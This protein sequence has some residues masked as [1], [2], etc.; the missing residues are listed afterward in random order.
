MTIKIIN[1]KNEHDSLVLD[2]FYKSVYHTRNEFEAARTPSW[3]HRYSLEP[4]TIKYLALKNGK[5]VGSL[6]LIT[7]LGYINGHKYKVGFFVDNCI[8]PEYST[9]YNIILSRLFYQI[10]K[11]AKKM[12]IDL[13]VGWDYKKHADHHNEL[14]TSMGYSRIDGINWIGGGTKHVQ[15]ISIKE[16]NLPLLWKIGL[17]ILNYKHHIR[18]L[19]LARLKHE[20][21]RSIHQKDIPEIVRIINNQNRSLDLSP[22]YTSTSLNRIMKKYNANGIVAELNGQIIGVLIYFLAPWSGWMYGKPGYTKRHGIF[23][24]KH[25]LEFGV[26]TEY[27]ERIGAH[28][29]FEAMKEKGNKYMFL[30]DVIDRRIT[31][32][33][34]AFLATG[35]NE[36]LYDYGT[37]FIKYLS[38]KNIKIKKPVYIPTNLVISPYTKRI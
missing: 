3:F 17:R 34:N 12:S 11:T 29:L 20:K 8:L 25:P 1:F 10:E 23:L 19:L 37:L 18:E 28:L 27:A 5:I 31:W 14:F 38:K 15:L 22:K 4:E 9:E 35:A 6:G 21:I 24:I 2:L 26:T 33:R 32:M 7:Y 16:F 13:L 30:V 36:F